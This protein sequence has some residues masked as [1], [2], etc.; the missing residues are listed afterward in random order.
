MSDRH[1]RLL[2]VTLVTLLFVFSSLGLLG[3]MGNGS[4]HP[5]SASSTSSS[6][7]SATSGGAWK[8]PSVVPTLRLPQLGANAPTTKPTLTTSQPV[9]E[10]GNHAVAIAQQLIAEKQLNPSSVFFPAQ[11]PTAAT[12]GAT[13]NTSQYIVNPVPTGLADIGHGTGGAYIYNTSSFEA[14]MQVDSFT[15]YNPG[16]VGW[17]AP[18]NYMTWQLNTVT[19]NVSYP[20][21]TDGEFWIQNVVH[22]NGTSL[23]FEDNIW[24]MTGANTCTTCGM[25]PNTLLTYSGTI[26]NDS[27]YYVY[28]P[29][30]NVTYPFSL[31]LYNN[32]SIEGGHP[33][34]YLNY[35][36]TNTTTGSHTGSFD[37][38]T[39]NGAASVSHPPQFEVN[40]K[41]NNGLGLYWDSELIFGGNGGGAN[42]VITN[43]NATANLNYWSATD[44]H[45]VGVPSAYDYGL[46]T[47]ETVDGVAAAYQGTT[48]LLSQG[49]SF[50]Y[51]L[52]NTTNSTWGPHAQP[53]WINVD[54][55]GL[56]NYGFAFATNHSSYT[57]LRNP[58]YNWS[59][60]PSDQ[61][62][63]TVTHLPPPPA[64]NPYIFE[65]WANGYNQENLT[66]SNN[67]TG[68][69]SFALVANPHSFDTPVYLSTEAQV[70]AFGA[71]GLPGV[72]LQGGNLW[73]NNT[74]A[75]LPVPFDFLSDFRF[76]EF[77][78]FAEY[79]LSTNISI[80]HFVQNPLTFKYYKYNSIRPNT[81]INYYAGVTQGYFFNYGTGVFVVTNVSVYGSA[82]LT[83]VA[84]FV[85]LSSVEFWATTD[86][87]VAY[88]TTNLDSFGIAVEDSQDAFLYDIAGNGGANAI[89]VIDSQ[90]V[91]AEK[92][93][94]NGTDNAGGQPGIAPFPT[95]GAYLQGDSFVDVFGLTA[96]NGSVLILDTGCNYTWFNDV[97]AVDNA[98]AP[99]GFTYPEYGFL[100]LFELDL[101]VELTNASAAN[102]TSILGNAFEFVEDLGVF[103]NNV[104]ATGVNPSTN[105]PGFGNT[106][107]VAIAFNYP[108]EG[109]PIVQTANVTNVTA[110]YGAAG[111]IG[112]FVIFLNASNIEAS[113]TSPAF[114]LVAANYVN[115]WDVTSQSESWTL[116]LEGVLDLNVSNVWAGTDSAAVI[117]IENENVHIWNVNGTSAFLG[118]PTV[119][120]PFVMG[121]VL[122]AG[123]VAI[124]NVN[125]VIENVSTLNYN[126][127]VVENV[128]ENAIISNVTE[129]NGQVGVDLNDTDGATLSSVFSYGNDVG[130]SFLDTTDVTLTAS[131]IEGSA[132]YG[133]AVDGGTGF[134]AYGNNFVANNGASTNG[135]YSSSHVQASVTGGASASFTFG[136]VGNYWSDWGGSGSY[137]ITATISDSAPLAAFVTNWLEIDETGLPAGTTWGFTLDTIP[138]STSA[139]LVY[140]PSW[141]LGDPTLGFVVNPPAGYSPTPAS[142]TIPYTGANLTETITFVR[143]HYNVT[144]QETGLPS[145]TQWSVTFNGTME[146]S[147]TGSIVFTGYY[148]GTYAYTIGSVANYNAAP[149]SGNVVVTGA[150][151]NVAIGFTHVPVA[152]PITFTETG[153]T[154]GTSWSVTLGGSNT[155]T[156]TNSTITFSELNGTYLY[157]IPNAGGMSPSPSGGT[158]TVSGMPV[159]VTVAFSATPV[160]K[161]AVSFEETGLASGTNWSVT[162]SNSAG[163]ST[164]YSDGTSTVMFN[165]ANGTYNW[166]VNA[167][168]GYQLEQATGSIQVV[169]VAQTVAVT[170]APVTYTI[171]F[172]ESGLPAGTTWSVTIGTVTHTSTNATIT[173][174]EPNGMYSYTIGA[175]SGYTA[176]AS[177]GTVTLSGAPTTES[178]TFTS[179]GPSTSSSSGLSTLEWALIGIVIAI[180]V[181]ALIVALVMRGRGGSK[182]GAATSTSTTES[183][184]A[185]TTT[186]EAWSEETPPGSSP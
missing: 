67:A 163:T 100:A 8:A 26:V 114:L 66:V 157:N 76:P 84:G 50:L 124:A 101:G 175:V 42:A 122:Q 33:A 52:W 13:Y 16:Y 167:V 116:F 11:P 39:F 60:S 80:N 72:T 119:I 69:A 144:F 4:A 40:G 136:P 105:P 149:S 2:T 36:L 107:N 151:Q 146:T 170:F 55:T 38:V 161:Y 10:S 117:A 77:M 120:D 158:V 90:Y 135:T 121:A 137:T 153:L 3:V 113:G 27:F 34:V 57:Y 112:E 127:G 97:S 79:N 47:G 29:T 89:A 174:Q 44:D 176:S 111:F 139:P 133:V 129:W 43:L 95:W 53:G 65:G 51:G 54:L 56:P 20:G 103:I 152:Y 147:V 162:L 23:Q 74:Q 37:Y 49:P 131:T 165:V 62:G 81:G 17:V 78:L 25:W 172:T 125:E 155:M 68:T 61:N 130:A 35:T 92:I 30:Y 142:G 93:S 14:A 7:S 9:A 123:V 41:Q 178:V 179:S 169:G 64:G 109:Q 182:A 141:S 12:P 87:T 180:I 181:I 94:A 99:G 115:I 148:P 73:I 143:A 86:S 110:S 166:T 138:Y 145:G 160:G 70:T 164:A 98:V 48:E 106:P 58:T 126:Y 85:S 134:Q 21:G 24:N 96:S 104:S 168:G 184:D 75:S 82:Y 63:N 173:F 140:I 118:T 128:S 186:T 154:A 159:G 83:Y 102:S 108:F 5:I 22:F 171:T 88:A 71:A 183:S 59:Y 28:G 32:I 91:L 150:N 156:S 19:V 6:T 45:Y 46:D 15:D 31:A 1:L 177:S 185:T 18:P 132:G